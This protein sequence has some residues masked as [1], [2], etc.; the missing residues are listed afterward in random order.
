MVTILAL[1]LSDGWVFGKEDDRILLMRPPY[2][3]AEAQTVS[4]TVVARSVTQHGYLAMAIQQPSWAD[5]VKFVRSE[6]AR[7]RK[8]DGR[9]LPEEGVGRAMLRQ[10]PASIVDRFLERIRTDLALL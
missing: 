8:A 5:T 10:A 3:L 9:P 1:D 4:E 6:V 2:R 7:K